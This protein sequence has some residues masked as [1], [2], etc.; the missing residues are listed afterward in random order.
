MAEANADKPSTFGRAFGCAVGA[1]ILAF[2]TLVLRLSFVGQGDWADTAAFY[3]ALLTF[4]VLA[5]GLHVASLFYAMR[6]ISAGG[7]IRAMA[8]G[9]A[10]G[11]GFARPDPVGRVLSEWDRPNGL[12]IQRVARPLACW[13]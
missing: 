6:G 3:A 2:G 9:R 13:G 1:L 5:P 10:R 8:D 12:H 11:R 4:L 7:N